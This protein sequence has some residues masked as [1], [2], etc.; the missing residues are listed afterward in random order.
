MKFTATQKQQVST[1]AAIL[2]EARTRQTGALLVDTAAE[3]SV[4]LQAIRLVQRTEDV[5]SALQ[6]HPELLF[7]EIGDCV[8]QV[9]AIIRDSAQRQLDEIQQ[10]DSAPSAETEQ[11]AE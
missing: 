9:K 4:V 2:A 10:P 3:A 11:D 6:D 5:V 7:G 8:E 1:V